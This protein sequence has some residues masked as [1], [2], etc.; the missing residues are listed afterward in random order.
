MANLGEFHP[1]L[2]NIDD[3]LHDPDGPV[4]R[5][6]DE[7]SL[8]AAGTARFAVHVY[9][10]TRK[11]TIWNPR[12]STAIL[13]PGFTLETIRTHWAQ[14]GSRGG[15]YGGVDA[16]GLPTVFLEHRPH[17]SVEMDERYPFLTTGLDELQLL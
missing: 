5:L 7:L 12:T 11:S 17:G 6:I 15:M 8:K 1:D 4:G 2:G 13:P 3:L 16:V 10:G 14:R 9:P